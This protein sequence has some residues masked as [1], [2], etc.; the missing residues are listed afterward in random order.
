MR[1]LS[2]QLPDGIHRLQGSGVRSS[3][4]DNGRG[5]GGVPTGDRRL[6]STGSSQNDF[7]L[8][9]ASKFT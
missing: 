6:A 7:D 2:V 8:V 1:L 5:A 4:Q 3:V 9:G